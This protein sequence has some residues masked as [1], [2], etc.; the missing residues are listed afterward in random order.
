MRRLAVTVSFLLAGAPGLSASNL[1]LRV[2]SAGQVT[3]KVGPG[4]S[5]PYDVVGELSDNLNEGLAM[6]S[7][8][9][10]FSGG[11]LAPASPPS[12]GPML[13]F[14]KPAGLTNPAGFGGTPSGG[15]LRQVG[16]AQNT[17]NN[18][19]A[20]YPSGAVVTGVA[21]S[22]SPEVLVSGSL[23]T[24]YHVGT[25][26]L[27]PGDFLANAIRQGEIGTPFWRVDPVGLGAVTPLSVTVEALAAAAP[28][29]IVGQTVAL[30]IDAGPA[31]A[32]RRFRLLGSITPGPPSP[33]LLVPLHADSYYQYTVANPNS[34]ILQNSSG[35]LDG[36]GRA[37][38]LFTPD[39]S[40]PFAGATAFH[41]FYVNGRT[42]FVS[43]VATVQVNS[44][45]VR[46]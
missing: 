24:P 29:V 13:S 10:A 35:V 41:A 34:P 26:T 46:K 17:I 16:G 19:F 1:D 2:E 32:G 23:T 21:Q 45:L 42:I 6:F 3:L 30:L 12:A 5:V 22:G 14:D 36:Q 15:V 31:N 25:F 39:A 37:T 43:N 40:F 11:P 28:T 18:A 7:F 9:L 20:P 44:P 8:D 27:S 38:A 33:R 4:A